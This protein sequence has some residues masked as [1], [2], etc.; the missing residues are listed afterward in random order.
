MA[1]QLKE[2]CLL[3]ILLVLLIQR[4]ASKKLIDVVYS[5][6]SKWK[7]RAD[8]SKIAVM[9]FSKDVVNGCWKWGEYKFPIM[10][11][12]CYS[13]IH[14]SSNGPGICIYVYKGVIR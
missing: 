8:V 5:Y 1:R 7:L 9:L 14:F 6:C 13:G 3:M 4:R 2:Y 11:S 12:Y 10:S